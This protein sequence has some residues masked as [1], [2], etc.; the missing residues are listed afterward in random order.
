MRIMQKKVNITKAKG[1]DF[2]FSKNCDSMKMRKPK[3]QPDKIPLI[4]PCEP[5]NFAPEYPDIK[6][7][8]TRQTYEKGITNFVGSGLL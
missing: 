6:E 5:L 1:S 3:A 8:I 4:K 7:Q 2:S